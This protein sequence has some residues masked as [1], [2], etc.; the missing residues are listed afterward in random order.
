[1]IPYVFD[2]QTGRF[3]ERIV[4]DP[5]AET[6]VASE[7]AGNGAPKRPENSDVIT[8]GVY[9][10]PGQSEKVFLVLEGN[11]VGGSYTMDHLYT[12]DLDQ[13]RFAE[14]YDTGIEVTQDAGTKDEL[15]IFSED[16]Y[17]IYIYSIGS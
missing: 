10:V 7:G 12:F 5:E 2:A 9:A 16:T 17:N 15:Y 4:F 13:E 14:M 1:M 8:H 11:G 3:Q 6:Q